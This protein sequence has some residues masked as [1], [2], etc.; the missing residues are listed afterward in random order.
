MNSTSAPRPS[1][2][3]GPEREDA[4]L[5]AW[6]NER[7]RHE[8]HDMAAAGRRMDAAPL[9]SVAWREAR[10][11]HSLHHGA[12]NAYSAVQDRIRCQDRQ[13]RELREFQAAMGNAQDQPGLQP[14]EWPAD[15]CPDCGELPAYCAPWCPTRDN[16]PPDDDGA[17]DRA[18]HMD[19]L[20]RAAR[21]EDRLAGD[22]YRLEDQ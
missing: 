12:A 7:Q 15:R 21:L 16:E 6:L 10:E 9:G 5:L 4:D 17:R 18:A 2:G 1:P 11:A 20:D 3:G 19:A 8:T 13:A 22:G 14:A